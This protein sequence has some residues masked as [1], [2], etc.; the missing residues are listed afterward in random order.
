MG[1]NK[2]KTN[3]IKEDEIIEDYKSGK[4]TFVELCEKASHNEGIQEFVK[5]ARER[6]VEDKQ[7]NKIKE[8]VLK[9]VYN[10]EENYTYNTLR[11]LVD[12]AIELTEKQATADLIKKIEETKKGLLICIDKPKPMV[13]IVTWNYSIAFCIKILE[14]L[15]LKKSMLELSKEDVQKLKE[16]K[17]LKQM[18]VEK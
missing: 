15:E 17:V 10:I 3:K 7:T 4:I 8:E 14:T 5:I 2:E 9:G 12:K 11:S 1:E 16:D 18:L 6:L 13:P